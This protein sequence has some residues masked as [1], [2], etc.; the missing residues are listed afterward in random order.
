M[1][2]RPYRAPGDPEVVGS[3]EHDPDCAHPR[4]GVARVGACP[5]G[6]CTDYRCS[7]CGRVFRFE[8]PD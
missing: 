7:A 5:A 8:W 3:V 6:C 2:Q 4:A 1:S